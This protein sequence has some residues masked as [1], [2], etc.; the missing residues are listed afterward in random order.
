MTA[1]VAKFPIQSSR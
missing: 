1:L